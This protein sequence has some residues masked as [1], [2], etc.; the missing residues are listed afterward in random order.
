MNLLVSMFSVFNGSFPREY[1]LACLLFLIN[2][3][4]RDHFILRS[5]AAT[6]ITVFVPDIIDYLPWAG[7]NMFTLKLLLNF[8][9]GVILFYLCAAVSVWDAVFAASCAY[10]VQHMAYALRYF[11]ITVIP[12]NP[13][14]TVF[15]EW[16]IFLLTFLLCYFLFVKRLSFSGNFFISIAGSISFML[17]TISVT[18]ILSIIA[19]MTFTGASRESI[20]LFSICRILGAL[21]CFFI[22][23]AQ[24]SI[25]TKLYLQYE[26]NL[27]QQLWNKQRAN[28]E[29]SKENIELINQKC[30]DLK[31]QIAALHSLD[32]DEQRKNTLLEIEQS[33]MIYDSVVKTG[34]EVLDV[35]LTEKSLLCER[36]NISWTC[37]ADG[38]LLENINPIDLYTL[39]GNSLDNAIESV[40]GINEVE[41]RI[42]AVTL[43]KRKNMAVLQIENY[44][45]QSLTFE[46]GMPVTTKADSRF[47]GYGMKSIRS[48]AEK[49]GGSVSVDAREGIFMLSILIPAP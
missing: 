49:Y 12:L 15:A 3:T 24:T 43:F 33:V 38:K 30:H 19:Q 36:Q 11:V 37:M 34:N 6:A 9:T 1:F 21:C 16:S 41:K 17:V 7:V 25:R 47:H 10:A 22:L 44:Y 13:Q 40:M 14:Q 23:W 48:I 46:D 2:L 26:F 8:S 39:F 28:Y 29:L 4:K 42:I 35:V 32:N 5:I 18:Y 27:Q 20:I 45:G 31:H